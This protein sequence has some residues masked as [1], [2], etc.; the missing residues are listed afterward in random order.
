MNN[1]ITLSIR[2]DGS[3]QYIDPAASQLVTGKATKRRA[4]HVLP[5]GRI[6]RAAF[7]LLRWCFGETGAVAEW[8]RGWNCR[9]L[10]QIVDGPTAGPFN[11]RQ[12]AIDWEVGFIERNVL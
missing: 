8:T 3:V 11:A 6:R 2:P 7:I 1:R 10:V 4:S 9:W 12:A 5:V